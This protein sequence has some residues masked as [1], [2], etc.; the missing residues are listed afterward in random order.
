MLVRSLLMVVLAAAVPTAVA[1]DNTGKLDPGLRADLA[2]GASVRLR[3]MVALAPE[4]LALRSENLAGRVNAIR[5]A[6][7]RVLAGLPAAS[8]TVERRWN[9]VAGMVLEIDA[10]A[11]AALAA[12]PEV[13]RI[14]TD[15][16]AGRGN[17]AQSM[18]LVGFDS[19]ETD[20]GITGSGSTIAVLDSGFD[21]DHPDIANALIGERCFAE[22]GAACPGGPNSAEDDFG[23]GTAVAGVITSDGIVAPAGGTLDTEIFAVKVLD[24]NNSFSATTF[25]VDGLD[26]VINSGIEFDAVNMS[27]GTFAS[28]A[29]DCDSAAAFTVVLADAVDALRALG[30]LS[31][32]STGN[33]G[34]FQ[35]MQAPACVASAISVGASNDG[36][37]QL[38]A[39]FGC[40]TGV[41]PVDT[42]T[43]YTNASATTDIVA[44]GSEITTD[45]V[46]GGFAFWHGTSFAAPTV[47]ACVAAL[48]EADP[49]L[50]PDEIEF[51]M[52][53]TTAVDV[54]VGTHDIGRLDCLAAV[55]SVLIQNDFDSDGVADDSDNCVEAANADQ[56]D[57][58]GDGIG[59]VCD[60]DFNQD[61]N[62]DFL[63]LGAMKAAFFLT[64]DLVSD[65]NGDSFTDF[66]DLGILKS[67][68]FG[69]PGPSGVAN[70][71]TP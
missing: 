64:G 24:S 59:S 15:M 5:E 14:G 29:G 65:L 7:D 32:V 68:F 61:C 25:V 47:A 6:S 38:F 60:P 45:D 52:E 28:F 48:R 44:P 11:V 62:I 70:L 33:Q 71:C 40:A 66:L 8:Y 1:S 19:I 27:L 10:T 53:S 50:T 56:R 49:G 17:L 54:A 4:N 42:A 9:A 12:Q 41:V 26:F 43:C 35:A 39:P 46:G 21:T 22:G 34:N 67:L 23:H 36:G 13:L 30:T 63:D 31:V 69:T 18:P 58:D 51:A 3:V 57:T 37:N 55:N 20:L 2:K 16:G